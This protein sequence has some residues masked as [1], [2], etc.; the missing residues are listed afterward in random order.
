M[1][2]SLPAPK[3]ACQSGFSIVEALVA[4]AMMGIAGGLL[5]ATFTVTLAARRSAALDVHS[6]AVV[7][8]RIAVLARRPCSAADTSGVDQLDGA[9]DTWSAR[10]TESAWEFSD[11]LAIP[12]VAARA[13]LSG[14]VRCR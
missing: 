12:G 11:S 1:R 5:A 6:A 7:R 4:L 10:R 14:R 9:V 8:T 2:T 3:L 13:P